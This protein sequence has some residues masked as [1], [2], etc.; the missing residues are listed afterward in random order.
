ML[1]V[2]APFHTYVEQADQTI[3][4][5]LATRRGCQVTVSSDSV[6]GT[7]TVVPGNVAGLV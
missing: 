3:T 6:P 7:R 4:A 5:T 1:Y 2:Y